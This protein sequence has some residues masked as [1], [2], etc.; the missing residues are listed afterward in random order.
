MG[1]KQPKV[2]T[3]LFFLVTHSLQ[4]SLVHSGVVENALLT[5]GMFCDVLGNILA[6]TSYDS[7]II[8]EFCQS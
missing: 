5:G 4:L 1:S 2:S 6:L 3:Y 7:N 8:V